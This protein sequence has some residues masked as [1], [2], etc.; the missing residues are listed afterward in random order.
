MID[1]TILL[2]VLAGVLILVGLA[3]TVLPALPGLPVVYL[4]MVVAAWAGDFAQIGVVSLVVLGLLTLLSIGIDFLAGILGARRVGASTHA[5]VGAAIGTFV[6]IFF[7]LL[8][9]VFGPFVGALAGELVHRPDLL[10]ASRV[11]VGTW[12]GILVGG[13]AKIG[14]AFLMLGWFVLAYVF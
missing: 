9:L 4:G 5:L 3:G 1:A 13:V 8:G 11:G 14:L 2:Y 6:G 12:I 10:H 7:G